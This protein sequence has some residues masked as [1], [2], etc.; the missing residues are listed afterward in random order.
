MVLTSWHQFIIELHMN[1]SAVRVRFVIEMEGIMRTCLR[2][3]APMRVFPHQ[4]ETRTVLT[5]PLSFPWEDGPGWSPCRY[6]CA[7]LHKGKICQKGC[8]V[9]DSL[10]QLL[11][12]SFRSL[13]WFGIQED[14]LRRLTEATNRGCHRARK[15]QDVGTVNIWGMAWTLVGQ[16]A[17]VPFLLS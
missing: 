10:V 15:Q 7:L 16:C 13:E 4:W 2:R 12:S 5:T 14:K 1:Q 6:G 17:L 8:C 11:F 3:T 9:S